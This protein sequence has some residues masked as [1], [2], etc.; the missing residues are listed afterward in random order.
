MPYPYQIGAQPV[1]WHW[2]INYERMRN[3]RVERAREGMAAEELEALVCFLPDNVRYLSS[4]IGIPI[5]KMLR[6]VILPREGELVLYEHGGD[7]G[8]VQDDAPWLKGRIRIAWPIHLLPF[9]EVRKWAVQLKETLRQEFGVSENGRVGFDQMMLPVLQAL[10]EAG[11]RVVDAWPALSR[12]R[13]IKT[14]DEIE[15]LRQTISLAEIGFEV[16]RGMLK[17]GIRENQVQAA[18]T[19]AMIE[20]GAEVTRGICTAC[21]APYWRTFTSP[22]VARKG[23]IFI[24]DRVQMMNGYWSD[25][26]RCFVVGQK[27]APEQK[28]LFY[29]C[30]EKLMS[31]IE[32]IKPGAT[33][34]EVAAKLGDAPD[35]STSTLHFGHGIGIDAHEWPYMTC[36]T[37]NYPVEIQP[38]M[39]FAVETYVDNGRQGVRLEENLVVTGSGY[40]ILSTYPI[41]G[42][43]LDE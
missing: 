37:P 34:G 33:T 26:V 41:Q 23:D 8:R 12:A 35:H 36:V 32:L 14:P 30:Y 13:S 7:I 22:R 24:I 17:P 15:C 18:M 16:A 39:T 40:E 43:M 27:P 19:A 6:Y 11:V 1:D 38:G 5:P 42:G 20:R 4:T 2:S 21:S 29:R 9:E 28:D 3:E 25:Y 31:A 10:Q